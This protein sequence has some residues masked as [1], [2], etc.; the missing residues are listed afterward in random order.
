MESKIKI[1][2]ILNMYRYMYYKYQK[3]RYKYKTPIDSIM[4]LYSESVSALNLPHRI[5]KL[6]IYLSSQ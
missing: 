5:N 1:P 4:V 3:P 6:Y 2:N